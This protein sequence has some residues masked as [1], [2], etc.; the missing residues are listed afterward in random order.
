MCYREDG[1]P[2]PNL[3]SSLAQRFAKPLYKLVLWIDVMRA[4]T[5]ERAIVQDH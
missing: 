5:G 4:P 1:V 2:E 3:A